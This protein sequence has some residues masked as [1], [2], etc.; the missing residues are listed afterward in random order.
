VLFPRHGIFKR[1]TWAALLISRLR[2][3]TR[4]EFKLE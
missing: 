3:M 4:K 2:S 1:I